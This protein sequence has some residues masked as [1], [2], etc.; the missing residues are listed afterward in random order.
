MISFRFAA[1][2]LELDLL[3]ATHKATHTSTVANCTGSTGMCR[4]ATADSLGILDGWMI[5]LVWMV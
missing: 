3:G 5:Q 2:L 4:V 1:E